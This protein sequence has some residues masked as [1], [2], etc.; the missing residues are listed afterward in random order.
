MKTK[1]IEFWKGDFGKE[2]TDRNSFSSEEWD[3]F[4]KANW[5]TT[6]I[7]M[8]SRFLGEL[9]KDIKILEVGCNI[10]MQLSGLQ[11]MGFENIYGIEL[12]QYAVEEAKKHTKNINII[13]GSGFDLPFKNDYF[14][15]VCTNGVLIH[16]LP[17]DLP[18]I[19][20]E[21]Y[22]CSK[23]Y[24]WGFEYFAEKTTEIN[25][26]GNTNYLWKADYAALF[27]EQFPDLKLVKKEMY[28]Y[29]NNPSNVDYMY[30]LEKQS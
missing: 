7:D 15:V 25:Y 17:A 11:R 2:Y 13:C 8:N 3:N 27:I 22:R 23:K 5:G 16:I 6:K 1:Q 14:D 4:Y 9:P 19:M 21:M 20:G 12:Q 28:P 18:K 10:G 30:L 24:I 29:I 26:R